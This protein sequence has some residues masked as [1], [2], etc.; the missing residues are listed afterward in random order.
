MDEPVPSHWE[1]KTQA[2]SSWA[3]RPAGPAELL[4]TP[5][6]SSPSVLGQ[7]GEGRGG[8]GRG[9]GGAPLPGW[10]A[11]S[12]PPQ[13]RMQ[14]IWELV[15]VPRPRAGTGALQTP[16][17]STKPV[18][19]GSKARVLPLPSSDLNLFLLSPSPRSCH[20]WCCP[21]SGCHNHGTVPFS[22]A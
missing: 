7:S 10:Q 16:M 17:L 15:Q 1:E 11:L 6:I 12:P 4:A 8:T 14:P 13:S 9:V 19:P 20:L 22:P 18:L 3:V 21:R 5:P 2:K